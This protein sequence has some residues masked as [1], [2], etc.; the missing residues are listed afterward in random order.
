MIHYF[1]GPYQTN[2]VFNR[3]SP[4]FE[5]SENPPFPRRYS[6]VLHL[7]LREKIIVNYFELL[8]QLL[9][10]SVPQ[11]LMFVFTPVLFAHDSQAHFG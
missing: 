6:P 3:F 11:A 10:N 8:Q 9:V 2:M 5:M 4:L 1:C 7:I